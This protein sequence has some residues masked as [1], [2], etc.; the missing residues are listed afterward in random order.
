[1]GRRQ[2][3][4]MGACGLGLVAILVL[5]GAVRAAQEKILWVRHSPFSTV[6]VTQQGRYR[7]LKFRENGKDVEQSRCDV[8]RPDYLIHEYSRLQ[9]LGLMFPDQVR[10]VLVVG[11]GGGSLSKALARAYPEAR[12]DSVELD[13]VVAQAARQW[14]FYH[15]S[16]RVRTILGDAREFLAGTDRKYDLIFLDAFDGLEVPA[17]LRS[18]PFYEIVRSHLTPGGAV[19]SNLHLRS[20]QYGADRATLAQVF[21]TQ[22]AFMGTGLA[23]VVSQLSEAR[24][25]PEWIATGASHLQ[26]LFPY[27]LEQLARHYAGEGEWD[28]TVE[29]IL[30]P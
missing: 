27:P 8:K 10:D 30:T 4:L 2:G 9:L 16:D 28:R 23:V 3:R 21:P 22:Y 15:E 6:V 1:M 20:R 11:L 12:L 7:I 13:P 18:R 14:F 24:R 17:P 5:A 19:I 26:K 25:P 29:P